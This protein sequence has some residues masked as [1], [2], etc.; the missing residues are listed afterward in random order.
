MVVR[1]ATPADA[2]GVAYVQTVSWREAYAGL[3]PADFLARRE[4]SRQVWLDRLADPPAGTR[5]LV[6]TM[7]GPGPDAPGGERVVGFA[8]V[9]PAE[10]GPGVG[11]LYALY[12][13][14]EHWGEGVGHRLHAAGMAALA[15][16]GA[17]SAI[18]WVLPANTRAV[19]FYRRE[20]WRLDG[21][22]LTHREDGVELAL[23]RMVRAL[24]RP[25][26]DSGR[27]R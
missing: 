19:E 18:L 11:H 23:V 25:A 17:T 2:A 13:L 1:P 5:T 16:T 20:G 10:S 6:A 21:G 15:E 26:Q 24:D 7:P 8:S 14:A 12:L 3:L 22:T 4:V 27:E 9:G